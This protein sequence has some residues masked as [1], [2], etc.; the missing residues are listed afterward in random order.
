MCA[1]ELAHD[2]FDETSSLVDKHLLEAQE[3]QGGVRMRMLE[4][5]R[6]F[7][8]EQLREEGEEE[9]AYRRHAAYYL[10]VAGQ[11][12]SE[13]WGS[14]QA[15]WFRRLDVEQA[16]LRVA[17]DWAL[18]HGEIELALRLAGK[19]WRFWIWHGEFGEWRRLLEAGLTDA[20]HVPAEV[21]VQAL[22]AAAWL[23]QHQQDYIAVTELSEE[24]LR[25]SRSTE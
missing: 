9:Q 21:R 12:E 1:D 3:D 10:Q 17:L 2:V 4:V 13:L 11:A 24:N 7:A 8:L 25:I 22:F 15:R 23:A 20:S 18:G 6:E 19:L 14:E 5:V 16:N